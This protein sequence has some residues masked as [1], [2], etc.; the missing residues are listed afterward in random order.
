M[1]ADC[2]PRLPHQAR[3]P[4]PVLTQRA[5][6]IGGHDRLVPPDRFGLRQS[7]KPTDERSEESRR[8]SAALQHSHCSAAPS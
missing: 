2:F 7:A 5:A 6:G 1:V 4:P 3:Q 8:S